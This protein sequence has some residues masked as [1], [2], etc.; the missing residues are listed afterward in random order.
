MLFATGGSGGISLRAIKPNHPK[1]NDPEIVY[2]VFITPPFIGMSF[3]TYF[4]WTLFTL[5]AVAQTALVNERPVQDNGADL[6][7]A[8][9]ADPDDLFTTGKLLCYYAT[10]GRDPDWLKRYGLISWNIEHHADAYF[11]SLGGTYESIPSNLHEELKKMWI[12][13]VRKHAE[14]PLVLHNAATGL[15]GNGPS[16]IRSS[17]NGLVLTAVHRVKPIYPATARENRIQGTVKFQAVIGA[18]GHVQD[19]Q[20]VFGHPLLVAAA[21]EA[22]RQWIYEP[23]VQNG[24]PVDAITTLDVD[25]ILQP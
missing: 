1:L 9:R 6:E 7:A 2:T 24:Y 23:K 21:T 11:L 12:A 20:L 4:L 17:S 13:Q 3:R 25:F 15:L 16:V 22:A 18:N 14:N 10:D 5:S 19:L 8:Q